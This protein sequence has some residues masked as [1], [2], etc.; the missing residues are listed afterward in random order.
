M[1]E[2]WRN[3]EL[4]RLFQTMSLL[5]LKSSD[6]YLRGPEPPIFI[7]QV[8]IFARFVHCLSDQ[9]FRG[10]VWAG[11]VGWNVIFHDVEL[12]T[13]PRAGPSPH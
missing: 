3:W 10:I 6:S 13:P 1:S 2:P 4:E 12:D 8:S 9:Y 11:K 7:S 5:K